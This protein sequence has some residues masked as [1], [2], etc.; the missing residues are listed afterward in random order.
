MFQINRK[1]LEVELAAERW[2]PVEG[3]EDRYEVSDHGNVRSLVDEKQRK[4]NVPLL[5]KLNIGSAGYPLVVLNKKGVPPKTANVHRLVLT[6]FV[7]PP[8]KGY[9]CGHLDGS[10]TNNML[11]NLKWITSSENQLHRRLHGTSA[12]GEA[13][14]FSKLTDEKVRRM[15][16]RYA[17][18]NIGIRALAKQFGITYHPARMALSG[19]SW[20]HIV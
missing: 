8:P 12:Q 13:N 9:Q 6:A 15:R 3:Y 1:A 18:G 10:R 7:G 19:K 20:G 11:S 16:A 5:L 4:R 2:L 14:G 17:Q